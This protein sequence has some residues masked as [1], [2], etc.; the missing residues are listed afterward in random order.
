MKMNK[1]FIGM[2]AVA[3]LGFTACSS[4]DEPTIGGN[5]TVPE[6][7][8]AYLN[9]A[10][11]NAPQTPASK[12]RAAWDNDNPNDHD[13]EYGNAD[14]NAVDNA[15]FYFFDKNQKYLGLKSTVNK[16]QFSDGTLDNVEKV[17]DNTIVLEGLSGN[18]YPNFMMTVLNIPTGFEPTIGQTIDQVR[19]ELVSIKEGD[20]FVMS[21]SSYDNGGVY[22]VNALTTNDFNLV[23]AGKEPPTSDK[24]PASYVSVYVERLAAKVQVGFAEPNNFVKYI[25]NCPVYTVKVNIAGNVND[26][27]VGRP[28]ESTTDV[29]VKFNNWDLNA[30]TKTSYI[31][32]NISDLLTTAPWAGWSD[33]ERSRSWWAEA[34][35]VYNVAYNK[36]N[37]NY[38]KYSDAKNPWAV[39]ESLNTKPYADYCPEN[40][41]TLDVLFSDVEGTKVLNENAITSV[42][43]AAQLFEDEDCTKPLS[44]LVSNGVFFKEAE[45]I[46]YVL[47]YVNPEYYILTN[48]DSQTTTTETV[49]NKTTTTVTTKDYAG[50]EAAQYAI[51][52]TAQGVEG[53]GNVLPVCKLTANEAGEYTITVEDKEYVI[54]KKKEDVAD[55]AAKFV[56]VTADD[57]AAFNTALKSWNGAGIASVANAYTAGKMFYSVPIEHNQSGKTGVAKE[58]LGKY[59]VVRNHW[60]VVNVNTVLNIGQ[61]V[62]I[63]GDGSEEEKEIIVNPKKP[64]YW[65]GATIN[66]LSWKVVQNSV[67]L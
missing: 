18:E 40:T 14:E 41:N 63:P 35:K 10:L 17:G 9:V 65:L 26:N 12:S 5:G 52:F 51:G 36:D 62:F 57:I 7:M 16:P 53:T 25:D 46:K 32:K 15:V 59:G 1:F 50:L 58:A 20:N 29:Y 27:N 4:D 28:T 43:F 48:K 19:K 30:T 66:I 34:A 8:D 2:A 11:L 45:F 44:G 21:T 13:F 64:T 56:A 38:V 23:P 22:A 55:G 31:S 49:E 39:G 42:I 60:Y 61:G 47:N 33:A 3:L 37:Y 67:D 54:Y 6:G 24:N